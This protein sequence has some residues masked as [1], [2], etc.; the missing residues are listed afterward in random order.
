MTVFLGGLY[1][2]LI[3]NG[4]IFNLAPLPD[5]CGLWDEAITVLLILLSFFKLIKTNKGCFLLNNDFHFLTPWLIIVITGVISNLIWGYAGSWQ[6]VI[7]DMV[8]FLK[9]PI[10]FIA[11]RF[12]GYDKKIRCFLENKGFKV[13]KVII[14]VIFAFG[15]VSLF[16]DIGLSQSYEIRHGIYSYQFL[17]NHPNSLGL[18]MVLLLCLIDSFENKH[19]FNYIIMCLGTL[20]LT[21]RTKI[22]AFVAVFIYV[23]YGEKWSKKY[24]AIFWLSAICLI[25]LVSYG[26]LSVVMKWT[27]SGRMSF[28]TESFNLAEKCF[29][30]GSG[31]G[32]FASHVSGK[33][34][35]KLYSFIHIKEIFDAKGNPTAVLGDTGYPYYI[36]QFGVIGIMLLALSLKNLMKII[37]NKMNGSALLLLIY[38]GIALTGES[39]LLNAGVEIAVTLAVIIAKNN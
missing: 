34:G 22:F 8:G 15:V 21:M 18:V 32:T 30:L 5:F 1:L 35:S 7:R 16:K 29:P 14:I 38:L 12:L 28:W 9:F 39:T 3:F 31:F 24:K 10:C 4:A 27:E 36:A 2:F 25:L 11:I 17:F 6:A 13:L 20:V 33:Y 37:N 19:N 23:K 26:K